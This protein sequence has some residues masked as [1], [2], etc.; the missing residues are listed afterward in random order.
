[1]VVDVGL[2]WVLLLDV[3]V[4]DVHVFDLRVVVVMLVGREEVTPVLAS[5]QVMGHVVVL[6]AV[7]NG[8][9]LVTAFA[10]V[11]HGSPPLRN[12]VERPAMRPYPIE[13]RHERRSS[14]GAARRPNGERLDEEDPW[15]AFRKT[16][17][18][19]SSAG[20]LAWKAR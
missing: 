11:R 10:P 16:R 19:R 4:R 12:D 15:I 18:C 17:I 13:R 1:V 8:L 20:E 3:L 6:V 2:P 5:M 7:D 9:V 14:V